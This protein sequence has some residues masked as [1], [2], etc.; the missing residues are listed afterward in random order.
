MGLLDVWKCFDQLV[1]VLIQYVAA[2]AGL[3]TQVWWAYVRL[4]REIKVVNCLALGAGQPYKKACSIPQGCPFSMTFLALV[5]YPWIK[6][7]RNF[8]AVI[9]RTLADDLSIWARS[10]GTGSPEDIDDW[11]EQWES[12][13]KAT[14]KFLEH[15]GARTA[16][17]KS[18][19]LAS[20]SHLRRWAKRCT[21]GLDAVTIPV[22]GS[23]RDL[24]A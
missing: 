1:P 13:V 23:T 7:M 4:M 21:W 12:A 22:T 17:Q 9:P 24:W 5:T 2:I 8:T 3:P 20:N 15:M 6:I 11:R 10:G 14:L 19:V 16:H 18:L